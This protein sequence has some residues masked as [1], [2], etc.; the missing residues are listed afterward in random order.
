MFDSWSWHPALLRA[1]VVGGGGDCAVLMF[2]MLSVPRVLA[3]IVDNADGMVIYPT[4]QHYFAFIR[5]R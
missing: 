2:L 1:V 4:V 3:R 5:S